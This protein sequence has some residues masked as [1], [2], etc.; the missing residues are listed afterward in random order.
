MIMNK[1]ADRTDSHP[2]LDMFSVIHLSVLPSIEAVVSN[3]CI[4]KHCSLK[5]SS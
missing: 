5:S 4:R 3:Y 1:E 2:S